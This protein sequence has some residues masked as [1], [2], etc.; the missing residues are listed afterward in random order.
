MNKLN[1]EIRETV[2]GQPDLF[3]GELSYLPLK[4]IFEIQSCSF[5]ALPQFLEDHM[6]ETVQAE[7][8]M[9]KT[10]E[11]TGHLEEGEEQNAGDMDE[12][13]FKMRMLLRKSADLNEFID[14]HINMLIGV[15]DRFALPA[16]GFV[17][18]DP[19]PPSYIPIPGWIPGI[20][21][22]KEE[23]F[24]VLYEENPEFLQAANK[25]KQLRKELDSKEE[26]TKDEKDQEFEAKCAADRVEWEFADKKRQ[27]KRKQHAVEIFRKRKTE[28]EILRA[29]RERKRQLGL[30]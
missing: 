20:G 8:L 17:L 4:L 16:Y 24:R 18:G 26:Q 27:E 13:P 5:E 12:M 19:Q 15:V 22:T 2:Q 29:E 11:R 6:D 14:N 25:L 28:I 21:I 3:T 1:D 9:M 10:M 7:F 23:E 30:D